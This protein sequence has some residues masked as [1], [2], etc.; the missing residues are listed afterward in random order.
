MFT[1]M[2]GTREYWSQKCGDLEILDEKLGPATFFITLSCAEYSWQE[3]RSF[4]T[5]VNEDIPNVESVTISSLT[6]ID[7]VSVCMVFENR[8]RAFLNTVILDPQ[9]PVGIVT[10]YFWRLE[11]QARGA[12]HIHMKIWV[13]KAP[14]F[15]VSTNEE[16]L[17][18]IKKYITCSIPRDHDELKGLVTKFQ[19]H[20]CRSS[21]RRVCMSKKSAGIKCRYGFPRLI[22]NNASMN[23]VAES[24]KSKQSKHTVKIYSL[25]RKE[26]E[27]FIN[28]YNPTILLVWA[29]NMDIQYI[30]ESSMVLNR[31]ITTECMNEGMKLIV[32]LS[33][34]T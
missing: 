12:P 3:T 2:R 29:A 30:G 19:T 32:D 4:L 10:D 21:C 16:V 6:A 22:N 20:E 26:N 33:H 15:G 5:R 11:Y 23:S 27:Q 18:F 1:A 28:D 14:I 7:P 31:Y 9:G 13:E 24:V 17:N 8:W 25:E 34:A